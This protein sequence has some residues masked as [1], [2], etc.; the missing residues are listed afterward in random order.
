MYLAGELG[1]GLQIVIDNKTRERQTFDN[2]LKTF[3]IIA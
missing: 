2:L 3:E 1:I